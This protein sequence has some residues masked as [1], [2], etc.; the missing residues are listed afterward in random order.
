[1]AGPLVKQSTPWREVSTADIGRGEREFVRGPR[2]L[3]WFHDPHLAG[4]ATSGRTHAEFATQIAALMNIA[5]HVRAPFDIV[6]D[7]SRLVVSADNAVALTVTHDHFGGFAE[8]FGS[9]TRRQAGLVARDWT[10][11]YW[12]G[13]NA[14]VGTPWAVE[15]FLERAPLW[16]WLGTDKS[17]ADDVDALVADV[18]DRPD[19]I[20]DVLAALTWVLRAEPGLAI[21]DAAR[22]LGVAQRSLQR[23]LAAGGQTFKALQHRVRLERAGTLLADRAMKIESIGSALGFAS[24]SYFTTWFRRAHGLSPSQFRERLE[25]TR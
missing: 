20:A 17:L 21:E 6:T 24:T 8:R 25:P 11:P 1:M 2:G 9:V 12:K 14:W 4:V 22:L 7:V 13:I 3:V 16:E 19:P 10:A 5:P 18:L 23:A 15:T